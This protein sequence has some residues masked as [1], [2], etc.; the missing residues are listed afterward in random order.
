MSIYFEDISINK[1]RKGVMGG[2]KHAYWID[3]YFTRDTPSWLNVS[4]I[5]RK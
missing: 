1:V 5:K 4:L 2:V 3:L